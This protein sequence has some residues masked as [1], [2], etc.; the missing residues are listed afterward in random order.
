MDL[1]EHQIQLQKA[2]A[3]FP[4]PPGWM[5]DG[6]W[7]NIQFKGKEATSI[8]EL[9]I[10]ADQ[11]KTWI[12]EQMTTNCQI[13]NQLGFLTPEQEKEADKRNLI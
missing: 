1:V 12:K 4:E 13:I 5:K 2:L 9:R 8:V 3:S 10:R 6:P 7:I 11:L